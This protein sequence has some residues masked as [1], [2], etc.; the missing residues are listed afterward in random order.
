MYPTPLLT[1][2]KGLHPE[3]T[4]TIHELIF[5]LFWGGLYK[6]PEQINEMNSHL[7]VYIMLVLLIIEKIA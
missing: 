5:W 7:P 2:V 1:K 6:N 4:G 3:Y